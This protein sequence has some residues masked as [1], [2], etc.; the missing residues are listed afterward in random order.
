M[1]IFGKPVGRKAFAYTLP[2]GSSEDLLGHRSELQSG[3]D[4]IEEDHPFLVVEAARHP[5]ADDVCEVR[6]FNG[7]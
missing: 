5:S 4:R 6:R 7:E 2:L 3:P 1:H